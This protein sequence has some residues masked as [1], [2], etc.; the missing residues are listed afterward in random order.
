MV[1]DQKW[2]NIKETHSKK[3]KDA[4]AT[5]L[6]GRFWGGVDN[7]LKVF[8]PL[9]NLLR[10]V[11]GD[12]KPSMGFVYGQ[13]FEAKNDIKKACKNDQ[14]VYKEIIA[15][16]DKKM[17]GRLDAPLHLTAYL[18]NPFYNYRNPAI[19]DD[20]DVTTAFITCVEQFYYGE[21]DIHNEVVNIDFT[22]FQR[23]D[24]LFGKILA[25]T[26]LK[27]EYNPG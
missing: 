25:M 2:D 9:V 22:K 18:L 26:N 12:V 13:L 10:L 19:F 7:C 15:I 27:F 1:V 3:G 8:E 24:G 11:D 21:E 17:R 4:Y 14:N 23:R 16:V 6:A 20:P 5:V